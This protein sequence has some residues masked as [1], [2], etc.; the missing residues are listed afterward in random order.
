MSEAAARQEALL[1]WYDRHR[2]ALPWREERDP[3][4][5]LVSEVMLQQTQ[6]A[7][8]APYYLR[9][10]AAF[11]TAEALAAAPLDDVLRLWSGLGYNTRAR[12]LRDAARQVVAGGW[13]RSPAGLAA[14][15]GVGPYTAAAI[16]CFAFGEQ[17]AAPD[18]NARRVLSRWRGRP[19]AGRD[20]V[21]AADQ[22]LPPARAADWNQA[23][24]DLGAGPCRAQQPR[25]EECPVAAWCAGPDGYRPP[26]RQAPFA[27]SA[28]QVRG[29]VLRALVGSPPRSPADL[30]AATGFDAAA[31]EAAVAALAADDLVEQAG[32]A[33]RVADR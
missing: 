4:R 2:R 14:L 33:V 22:E 27:G 25:C 19:L 16:A 8:V 11:P 20:L 29:A 23:L 26:P 18:A 12:R 28:R 32:E 30:A 6:A 9:F 31:V 7:R 15:P 5:V 1:A 21:E 24:M 13:P 3:Y 10:L 17:V